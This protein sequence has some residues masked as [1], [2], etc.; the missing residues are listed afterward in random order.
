MANVI[1]FSGND[2]VGLWTELTA[3]P[4][5]FTLVIENDVWD[6]TGFN[7]SNL[8][9]YQAT[10]NG[11]PFD[12]WLPVYENEDST[13][14]VRSS[15]EG[16][17]V[18]IGTEAY[19]IN[20]PLLDSVRN[21]TFIDIDMHV[22]FTYD[23]SSIPYYLHNDSFGA[24]LMNASGDD[25]SVT[26][27]RCRVYGSI[28]LN[29]DSGD[30]VYNLGGLVGSVFGPARFTDCVNY[31]DIYCQNTSAGVGGIIGDITAIYGLV[32]FERCANEGDLTLE[33]SYVDRLESSYP[34][35]MGGIV[36]EIKLS[37]ESRTMVSS[38]LNTGALNGIVAVGGIIGKCVYE[39][40]TISVADC[41]NQGA[42]WGEFAVGGILGLT[43]GQEKKAP[44]IEYRNISHCANNGAI[45]GAMRVG[46]II[47]DALW[48][49][50]YKCV[51]N[52]M[53]AAHRPE[54]IDPGI[55]EYI[56]PFNE[57]WLGVGGI[58]GYSYGSDI[59]ECHN[60]GAVIG[61]ENQYATGG[62]A[63]LAYSINAVT[64]SD[65]MVYDHIYRCVND[66]PVRVGSWLGGIVG[67]AFAAANPSGWGFTVEECVNRASVVASN[68]YGDG[69]EGAGG[70]VGYALGAVTITRNR[71]CR[72]AGT[73]AVYGNYAGGI[74][75]MVD[76]NEAVIYDG[77]VEDVRGLRGYNG[78]VISYNMSNAVEVIASPSGSYS[79]PVQ[80]VRRIL[81]M[82]KNEV[83]NEGEE[84]QYGLQLLR[85][86]AGPDMR[87]TGDNTEA[88]GFE[89]FDTNPTWPGI[90]YMNSPVELGD[91]DLGLNRMNGWN[92]SCPDG[93]LNDCMYCVET[94]RCPDCDGMDDCESETCA[95]DVIGEVA[96]VLDGVARMRAADSRYLRAQRT[97]ERLIGDGSAAAYGPTC[98]PSD[99]LDIITST[100]STLARAQCCST[101]FLKCCCSPDSDSCLL[102]AECVDP[103][104][105]EPIANAECALTNA[106]GE[107]QTAV[108]DSNG[109]ARFRIGSPGE[110]RLVMPPAVDGS[111]RDKAVYTANIDECCNIKIRVN[112]NESN[113]G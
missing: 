51:N 78:V 97:R 27:E 111:L 94:G 107:V 9:R 3:L 20:G 32:A 85:N 22:N 68:G 87:L 98:A 88:P 4:D 33:P 112:P 113:G 66:G 90:S 109:I 96:H 95:P 101:D 70:I 108:T 30:I 49:Y 25:D 84:R 45:S 73:V 56:Q 81:G 29:E 63:G 35:S 93:I 69:A 44:I 79:A 24:F 8:W 48:V 19:P 103:V 86:I 26:M 91:P 12:A 65:D 36:G 18:S 99:P 82:Y 47:G 104:T 55:E 1:T 92:A 5:G 34:Q 105:G 75:G 61:R 53:V 15:Q 110:Y 42:I 50:A 2:F 6:W 38:C 60:T 31:A 23:T 13:I 10:Y 80:G 52:K 83:D 64:T 89:S 57:N 76:V 41:E 21:V 59:V 54:W 102:C 39:K 16:K 7:S 72:S 62:I 11:V 58:A 43:L 71:L 100:E 28:I 14:T 77:Q 106:T 40:G 37:D 17:S 74:V 67:A 46:G